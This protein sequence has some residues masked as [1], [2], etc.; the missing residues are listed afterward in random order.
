MVPPKLVVVDY[1]IGNVFSVTRAF[2]NIGAEVTLT[3]DPEL[4]AVADRLVLPGVGAFGKAADRLRE[5]GHDQAISQQM[6]SG[7][8]FLGICVGMQLLMET[9]SEFGD[10]DGLGLLRGEVNQMSFLDEQQ[11]PTRIPQI[12]WYPLKQPKGNTETPW[13]KTPLQNCTPNS[14]F[15]FVHSFA[16]EPENEDEVLALVDYAGNDV[17]AAVRKDNVI[18]VQFHPERSGPD[19]LTV[20]RSFLSL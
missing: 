14:A 2:E 11:N 12:G 10:Y 6:S 15:Y 20:L 7:R 9:G 3:S 13:D 8:P 16:V 4:I 18:G 19:G 5:L 1:G 17:V